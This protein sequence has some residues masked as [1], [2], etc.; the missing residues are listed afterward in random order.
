MLLKLSY[1][2]ECSRVEGQIR[3]VGFALVWGFIIIFPHFF[4]PFISL[5]IRISEEIEIKSK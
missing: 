2:L 5:C 3:R 4:Y 1:E